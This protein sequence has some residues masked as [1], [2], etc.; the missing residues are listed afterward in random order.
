MNSFIAC[1]KKTVML[2]KKI[3]FNKLNVLVSRVHHHTFQTVLWKAKEEG[4]TVIQKE[5]WMNEYD[6]IIY[7]DLQH[8]REEKVGR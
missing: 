4:T 6:F 5:A 2:L 3:F 1:D 8:L 7:R